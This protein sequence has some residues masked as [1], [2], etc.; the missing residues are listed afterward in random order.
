MKATDN[1]TL[2]RL[3][4]LRGKMPANTEL[5]LNSITRQ[6][7]KAGF[8]LPSSGDQVSHFL[9]EKAESGVKISTLKNYCAILTRWHRLA[10]YESHAIDIGLKAPGVIRGLR[11]ERIEDNK[12]E[13]RKSAIPLLLPDALMIDQYLL[14]Q[15]ANATD[16]QVGLAVQDLALFR[17]LW[18][19]GCRESE[20]A[21]LKRWQIRFMDNPRA[22]ELTWSKTK[23][24]QNIEST[25]RIIPALP[26]ADPFGALV[27]WLDLYCP[28]HFGGDMGP[29]FVRQHR[30]GQWRDNGI[31]PNS[32]PL[33]LRKIAKKAGV[34]YADLLSGHSCRH[35]LATMMSDSLSLREVMD[36]FKWKR[37]ETAIGYTTNKGISK[38]VFSTL[39]AAAQAGRPLVQISSKMALQ[40]RLNASN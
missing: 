14:G 26:N 8:P 24:E 16:T 7:L 39:S 2:Q 20:I 35:G 38:T 31:H 9:L 10:G 12:P 37:A 1:L 5:A 25:S 22:I 3:S 21:T 36:Y 34:A 28:P 15:V 13:S 23:T 40:N 4:S 6:L 29:V 11:Q 32:I 18:W 30:N 17:I 19:S 33:W 27:D